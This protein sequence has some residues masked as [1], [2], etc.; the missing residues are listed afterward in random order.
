MEVSAKGGA[1]TWLIGDRTMRAGA[2]RLPPYSQRNVRSI[3][4]LFFCRGDIVLYYVFCGSIV[5]EV[6]P[7][8]CIFSARGSETERE[9]MQYQVIV[10]GEFRCMY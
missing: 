8:T 10:L 7:A 3:G 9:G 5:F 6:A 4:F 1:C 2:K